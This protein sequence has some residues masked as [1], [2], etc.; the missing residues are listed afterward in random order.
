[1]WRALPG[2]C[3]RSLGAP[4]EL[5]DAGLCHRSAELGVHSELLSIKF[6]L[7]LRID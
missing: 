4:A 7:R 5:L 1:M 3:A 6:T 2:G